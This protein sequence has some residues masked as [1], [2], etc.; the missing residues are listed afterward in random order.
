[1]TT[2]AMIRIKE[3][4][5]TT[6]IVGIAQWGRE[7]FCSSFFRAS[8]LSISGEY[9]M[10]KD[11]FDCAPSDNG[12]DVG[13]PMAVARDVDDP[14]VDHVSEVGDAV[15]DSVPDA[16][17]PV[18]DHVPEVGD[19]VLDSVPDVDDPVVD[20]VPDGDDPVVDSV[21]D[22][23]DPVI[24]PVS[25]VGDPVLDSVP[26]GDDPVVDSVPDVGDPVGDSDPEL[27]IVFVTI[28]AV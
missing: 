6:T 8:T 25:A 13:L 27:V 23:D 22:V 26:D 10:P 1:M 21:P 2:A 5:E 20:S 16:D 18:V 28:K 11:V 19:P 7:S 12:P 17:D 4:T 24:N 9:A 15:L 14:V 3:T